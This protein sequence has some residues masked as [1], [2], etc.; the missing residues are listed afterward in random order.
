MT[1]TS[2]RAAVAAGL[3]AGYFLGRTKKAKLALVV[4]SYALGRR[5]RLNP[6]ELMGE[7]VHRL[8]GSEHFGKLGERVRG[9]LL[10]GGRSVVTAALH[11][12]YDNVA[13]ALAERTRALAEGRLSDVVTGDD[14]D[15]HT[16]GGPADKD[17]NSD[18]SDNNDN[19]VNATDGSA[20]NG[21][22]NEP[23]A[24]TERK[25]RA[26]RSRAAEETSSGEGAGSGRSGSGSKGARPSGRRRPGEPLERRERAPRRPARRA[27]AGADSGDR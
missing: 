25:R 1:D 17:D 14:S 6:K 10:S 7:G 5:V 18:N 21:E 12:G 24:G 27:T 13:D 9:E 23:P 8:A 22:G 26:T 11:R 15:D 19:S 4:A 20:D 2:T 16:T 3:A